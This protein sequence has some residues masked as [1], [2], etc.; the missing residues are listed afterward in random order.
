MIKS[1]KIL[2]GE[3]PLF[4]PLPP[5]PGFIFTGTAGPDTL[6]GGGGNDTLNG[7]DGDDTLIGGNGKDALNG[8][9]GSDTAS[10][11]NAGSMVKAYLATPAS[12]YGAA[13]GDTYNS[14]ENLRGSNHNDQLYGDGFNN[15]LEGGAGGDLLN[16][17]AGTD[18]ASYRHA[19]FG[20]IAKLAQAAENTGEAFGDTYVS[21]E[22]LIGSDFNDG[23]FGTAGA[24]VLVGGKGADAL[25]GLG[26]VDTASYETAA[27]GVSASLDVP[28]IN[29]GEAAG[30]TYDSIENLTGS[31]FGDSLT[32]TAGVNRLTGLAGND[33]LEGRG[34]ADVLDGGEGD[35]WASYYPAS[36]G[37][38]ASLANPAVNTGDA[39]GDS[40]AS[41]E[42]LIGS[43]HNDVLT[44]NAADN[45]LRGAKGADALNGGGGFDTAA[46]GGA[47]EAVTVFLAAAILNTG[48]AAG[49][50]F[51]S[52][53]A[54]SGTLYDDYLVGNDVANRLTGGHGHDFLN[55][56]AGDDELV[57][58]FGD[59]TLV[60]SSGADKLNGG[61]GIDTVS[62]FNAVA[63]VM[64]NL[65][66]S[67]AN[68][69][70]DA[71]GDV[72]LNV[73]NLIGSFHSDALT[74]DGGANLLNGAEGADVLNG[75]GG[76]DTLTG[77][78]G[79]DYFYFGANSGED[80]VT[81][82]NPTEDSL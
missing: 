66:D 65:L 40:Y 17:G 34:G 67:T 36:A 33:I 46:Y 70:G 55:G 59:D 2:T 11:E 52:I 63:G 72:Y 61:Q 81:D 25:Y 4:A 21:I 19:A 77:G 6:T 74:G 69:G 26:G 27:G 15:I 54:V 56:G 45:V 37:V 10:Y 14:I 9:A 44:G 3:G 53:E 73:E 31:L 1:R 48:E 23:L 79:A 50:S 49:D 30:D 20:V 80:V 68:S 22:N 57:G 38:T 5:P 47:T 64:A 18:T 76:G 51:T 42:N 12:N 41:I 7:L 24:N 28:A 13:A 43:F 75:S 35:D 8:G 16:G 78:A 29:N 60:G 58:E 82:F 39:A 32:G 71:M 62:Y